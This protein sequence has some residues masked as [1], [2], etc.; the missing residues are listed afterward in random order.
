M[1]ASQST[2]AGNLAFSSYQPT[3]QF[4]SLFVVP[5]RWSIAGYYVGDEGHA[6]YYSAVNGPHYLLRSNNSIS[7]TVI[8]C[9]SLYS[10]L[11]ALS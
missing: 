10:L 8:R 11:P 1:S 6:D 4:R 2:V 9:S 3:I 5:F 7:V